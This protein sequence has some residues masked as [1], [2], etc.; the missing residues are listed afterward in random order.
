[1]TKGQLD[2]KIILMFHS[3]TQKELFK[4]A[5]TRQPKTQP[6]QIDT[7]SNIKGPGDQHQEIS[8]NNMS[9]AAFV[10]YGAQSLAAEMIIK[11]FSSTTTSLS[12]LSHHHHYC[13]VLPD[14]FV[15][16]VMTYDEEDIGVVV[17]SNILHY[18]TIITGP[19]PELTLMSA[20]CTGAQP[21]ALKGGELTLAHHSTVD[22]C[23][24]LA[25]LHLHLYPVCRDSRSLK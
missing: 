24:D 20:H 6:Q 8:S 4:D 12:P 19:W 18:L 23:S 22:H 10:W 3:K 1:M 14:L 17:G 2:D 25:Q 5:S 16:M 21:S 13:S 9:F 7:K 15:V 11:T